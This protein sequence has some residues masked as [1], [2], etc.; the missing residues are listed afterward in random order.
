MINLSEEKDGV[1]SDRKKQSIYEE[2]SWV[3]VW[4]YI[5]LPKGGCDSDAEETGQG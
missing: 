4:L 2:M 5:K 3:F 1:M